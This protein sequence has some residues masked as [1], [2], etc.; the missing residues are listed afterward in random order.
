MNDL[1]QSREQAIVGDGA[2]AAAALL[3]EGIALALITVL[4][5]L[6]AGAMSFG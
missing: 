2:H 6:T 1:K 3:R 5:Y 4:L